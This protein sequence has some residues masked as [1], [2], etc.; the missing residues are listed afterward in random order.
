MKGSVT[1][2]A[3]GEAHGHARYRAEGAVTPYL[4]VMPALLYLFCFWGYPA[5][6]AF[7]LSLTDT[8]L[9]TLAGSYT[10]LENYRR[11]FQD[12]L[13][14]ISLR[15][16]GVLLAAC[17]PLEVSIGLAAAL[18]ISRSARRYR[19]VLIVTLLLPWLFSEIVTAITWRWVF[20]EPFGLVNGLLRQAGLPQ[21][22]WLGRPNTA[23][24]ALVVASLWQGVGIST[25]VI[26]AALRSIPKRLMDQAA[27]DGAVGRKRLLHVVLPQ[28]KGVLLLNG[29]LVSIKSLASFSLVFA[30]TGGGPGYGTEVLATYVYRLTFSHYELGY[31]SALGVCLAV[32]FLGLVSIVLLFQRGGPA[33]AHRGRA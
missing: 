8:S 19:G 27:I 17:V 23:M 1:H 25:L 32:L 33:A 13:F 16:S 12:P 20:Q 29:M 6:Y 10:G 5:G 7:Y 14:W 9:G 22:P 4:F 26:L 3:A 11:L 21:V 31:A 24:A 2:A 30:L 18:Y 28:L 15:N